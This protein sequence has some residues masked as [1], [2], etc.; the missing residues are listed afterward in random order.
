MKSTEKSVFQEI[1]N[2]QAIR[3]P[4]QVAL[5]WPAHKVSLLLQAVLGG[6]DVRHDETLKGRSFGLHQETGVV[7]QHAERLIRCIVDCSIYKSDSIS[8][9]NALDLARS[10]GARCWEDSPLQLQ[11]IS[12]IGPVS[13]RRLLGTGIKTIDDLEAAEPHKIEGTLSKNPPFGMTVLA[14]LKTFPKLRVSLRMVGQGVSGFNH[15]PLS[16]LTRIGA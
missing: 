2:R 5:D 16:S 15:I 6:I 10:L 12:K 11:Q 8:A 1:N 4:I 3:F 13:V 9:R 14:E 7:M